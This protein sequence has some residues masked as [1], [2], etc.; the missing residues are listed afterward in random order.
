M[1]RRTAHLSVLAPDSAEL[2][3]ASIQ[4]DASYVID[5]DG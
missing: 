2:L 4:D 5:L 1:S 3:I